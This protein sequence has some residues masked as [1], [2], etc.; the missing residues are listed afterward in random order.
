MRPIL[1]LGPT[2]AVE[3]ALRILPEADVRPPVRAG[4]V[5]RALLDS[6]AA[7]GIIDGLYEQVPAV[8]HKEILFALSKGVHVYGAASMGALRAAELHTYGMVGL[9]TIFAAYASE[10]LEDDDEVSVNHAAAEHRYRPLSEAMVNL[11]FGLQTAE[12]LQRIAPATRD[13]LTAMAKQRFY[14]D[15]SWTALF[16]DGRAAGLPETELR[17]LEAWVKATRPNQKAEDA[18]VLLERMACDRGLPPFEAGFAFEPTSH[19]DRFDK[20]MTRPVSD[21]APRAGATPGYNPPPDP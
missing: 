9:G 16:T 21:G 1:F 11:R 18:I 20:S 3:E 15:R 14:A 5:R 6:P 13:A 8:W 17:A 2:L 4:D 12:R 19:W 10:A 7:I